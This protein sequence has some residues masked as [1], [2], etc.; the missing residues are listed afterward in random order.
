MVLKPHMNNLMIEIGRRKYSK[1]KRG[2]WGM[3]FKVIPNFSYVIPGP[4]NLSLSKDASLLLENNKGC[5]C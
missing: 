5:H 1:T 2:G 4:S 3:K